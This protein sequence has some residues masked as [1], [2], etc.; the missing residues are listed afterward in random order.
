MEFMKKR[1]LSKHMKEHVVEFMGSQ[2]ND[3]NQEE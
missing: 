2:K 3:K 1:S